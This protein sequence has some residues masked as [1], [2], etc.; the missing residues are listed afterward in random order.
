MIAGNEVGLTQQL[1]VIR[2]HL[3]HYEALLDNFERSVQFVSDT[4]NPALLLEVEDIKEED[5]VK[6]RDLLK[7]ECQILIDQ[8]KRLQNVRKMQ[9]DRLG[10]VMNLV[11][12]TSFGLRD[13][14]PSHNCLRQVFSTVTIENTKLAVRDSAI[15][16]QIAFLTMIFLPGTFVAVSQDEF[17]FLV[18]T[19]T[20]SIRAF[21]E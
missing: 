11:S 5:T 2:A 1:H 4:E 9:D 3:L 12:K 18:S 8:I 21:S 16:K 20:G 15:M 14:D 7:K 10:N 6:S 13:K 17:S 19:L